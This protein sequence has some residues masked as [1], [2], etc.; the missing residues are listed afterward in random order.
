LI[1]SY[2]AKKI[3]TLNSCCSRFGLKKRTV[4]KMEKIEYMLIFKIR[5]FISE[6]YSKRGNS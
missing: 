5:V 1:F 4:T 2:Y 6:F 3:F